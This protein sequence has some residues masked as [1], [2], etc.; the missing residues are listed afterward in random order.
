MGRVLVVDDEEDVRV[1]IRTNL[2]VKGHEVIE[3]SSGE[4]ALD[5][6]KA[7]D[8]DLVILDIM[9]PGMDGFEVLDSLRSSPETESLPVLMLTAKSS[10]EDRVNGLVK[11]AHDYLSKPFFTTE[12]LLRID[13]ILNTKAT[14]DSLR[15][16]SMTDPVTGVHNRRYFELRLEQL[17]DK[18][19]NEDKD[20]VAYVIDVQGTHDAARRNGWRPVDKVLARLGL[21]LRDETTESEE[22]FWL[23]SSFVILD[24]TISSAAHARQRLDEFKRR[25]SDVADASRK[26]I[27][28]SLYYGYA[29]REKHGTTDDF[30]NELGQAPYKSGAITTPTE[31][32]RRGQEHGIEKAFGGKLTGL[33]PVEPD[34]E[35]REKAKQ[36]RAEKKKGKKISTGMLQRELREVTGIASSTE[37]KVTPDQQ[38][39]QAKPRGKT[40]DP[41][42]SGP[43]RARALGGPLELHMFLESECEAA[44]SAP[45]DVAIIAIDIQGIDEAVAHSGKEAVDATLGPITLDVAGMSS[46]KE[47]TFWTGRQLMFVARSVGVAETRRRV[48]ELSR[49][50][51]DRLAP[52][53]SRMRLD[54]A[55][56]YAYYDFEE[57]VDKLIEKASKSP[58]RGGLPVTPLEARQRSVNESTD[59]Q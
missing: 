5:A 20:L 13:R 10:E 32:A 1:L 3:A 14:A 43:P 48:E 4:D 26:E 22:A 39:Q 35:E 30:F 40:T 37:R 25:V 34:R 46:D 19:R 23:G 59:T 15:Q 57:P 49:A 52:H 6:A 9:M 8:L 24:A 53:K 38:P 45:F 12:L 29:F 36:E 17:C 2:L 56:G 33:A 11:G 16:I 18:V 42:R 58:F 51:T 28:L 7:G 54:A 31:E 41:L 55:G 44:K 47:T 27:P 21:C 50:Y